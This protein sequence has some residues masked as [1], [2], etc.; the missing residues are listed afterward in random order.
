MA[1]RIR[2]VNIQTRNIGFIVPIM[3]S[4]T[5]Q[6][7]NSR[8]TICGRALVDKFANEFSIYFRFKK[9][10]QCAYL[11]NKRGYPVRVLS[12]F[13]FRLFYGVSVCKCRS[14][15]KGYVFDFGGDTSPTDRIAR[16]FRL[17]S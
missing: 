17:H 6:K 1:E 3:P 7:H 13:I 2:S 9:R 10:E 14:C 12:N 8:L 11:K 16:G 5:L 15:K 4:Q